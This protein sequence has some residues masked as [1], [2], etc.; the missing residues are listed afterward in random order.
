MTTA[1]IPADRLVAIDA[2]LTEAMRVLRKVSD[3]DA[4][5]AESSCAR[6]QAILQ[7]WLL[8]PLQLEVE[9]TTPLS[10]PFRDHVVAEVPL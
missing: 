9:L 5:H 2:A 1:R 10:E 8:K 7:V 3:M 4:I 6:A